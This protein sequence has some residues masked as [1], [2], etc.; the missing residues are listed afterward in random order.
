MRQMRMGNP[1]GRFVEGTKPS[2]DSGPKPGAKI[3]RVTVSEGVQ[4]KA[5]AGPKPAVK[6]GT[7]K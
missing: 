7:K 2:N 3:K 5:P 1:N 4:P 6:P